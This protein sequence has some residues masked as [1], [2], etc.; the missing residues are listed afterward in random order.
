MCHNLSVNVVCDLQLNVSI[1]RLIRFL[2]LEELPE[3]D[4]DSASGA[5]IT[6]QCVNYHTDISKSSHFVVTT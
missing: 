4:G 1:K 2:C 5:G 6:L 3:Y